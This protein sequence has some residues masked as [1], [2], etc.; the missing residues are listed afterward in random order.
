[1]R[2][3]LLG[4]LLFSL[5]ARAFTETICHLYDDASCLGSRGSPSGNPSTSNRVRVNPSAV[6]IESGLGIESIVYGSSADFGIVRGNGRVGAAISPSN[7][8]ETFFGPPGVE[9][10]EE[11]LRR[12]RASEKYPSQKVSL[13]T[14]FKLLSN[15]RSG[16]DRFDL[17]LGVM[18]KYN[19]LTKGILP[20]G[21]FTGVLG[22]LTFGASTYQDETQLNYSIY[23][24]GLAPRAKFLVDT[25]TIGLFLNSVVV[26]Y[27]HLRVKT[28]DPSDVSLVTASLL[29]KNV[30][31][32]AA[33]R[34]VDSSRPIYNF[35]TRELEANAPRDDYF[36]GVQ[37]RVGKRVLVGALYNY[38]LLND[39]SGSFTF[40]F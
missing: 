7:S 35:T 13:A 4:A 23:G 36:A 24:S 33:R 3:A 9:L 1:M 22:A 11:T 40:F 6:P 28:T 14:A 32:T 27:S 30:I 16:M 18:A 31:L 19:T 2:T 29:L 8:E 26:D 20:G 38:Y 15:K 12:K 37:V 39:V 25:Y 10:P 17:N 21:G 34:S 5:E